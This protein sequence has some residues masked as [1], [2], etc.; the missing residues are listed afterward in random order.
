MNN[1]IKLNFNYVLVIFFTTM[2]YTCKLNVHFKSELLNIREKY[3][4]L[5]FDKKMAFIPMVSL[6]KN[7]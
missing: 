1:K 2:V 4:N 3:C 7:R 6:K 5:I